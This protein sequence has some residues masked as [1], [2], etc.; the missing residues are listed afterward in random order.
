MSFAYSLVIADVRYVRHQHMDVRRRLLV[1]T[2]AVSGRRCS[3]VAFLGVV[4]IV[5]VVDKTQRYS[6]T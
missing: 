4:G 6:V 5:L 2:T 1:M 3:S